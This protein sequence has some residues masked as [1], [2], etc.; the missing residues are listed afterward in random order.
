[1]QNNNSYK[2]VGVINPFGVVSEFVY[3][4][5]ENNNKYYFQSSENNT[6]KSFREIPKP[7]HKKMI[8]FFNDE[9]INSLNINKTYVIGDEKIIAFEI[10]KGC[11][12]ISNVTDFIPFIEN[13]DTDDHILMEEICDFLN[14]NKKIN[15]TLTKTPTIKQII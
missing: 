7:L 9:Y 12:Y 2:L 8:H 14:K 3:P 6:I 13:F 10:N 4:I 1:M 5:F 15:K 11:F